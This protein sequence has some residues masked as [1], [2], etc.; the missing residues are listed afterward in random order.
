MEEIHLFKEVYSMNIFAVLIAMLPSLIIGLVSGVIG[1]ALYVM[2]SWGMYSISKRRGI[3]KPWLS[4]IPLGNSWMLGAISD[5]YQLA[6][7]GKEKSKRKILL[8]LPIA[9]SLVYGVMMAAYVVLMVVTVGAAGQ[10][11]GVG[12]EAATASASMLLPMLMLLVMIVLLG[13]M[14][15]IAVVYSVFTYIALFDLFRSCNPDTGVL[16]LILSI[17]LGIN[18][19]FVFL[20]RNKDLGMPVADDGFELPEAAE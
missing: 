15:V 1:I 3:S 4:W 2:M 10:S 7:K 12:P 11:S 8:G 18:G 9:M 5:H 20:D 13:V 14:L 16:F 19:F 6:A 17:V